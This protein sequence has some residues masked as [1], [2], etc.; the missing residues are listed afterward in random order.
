M[1]ILLFFIFLSYLSYGQDKIVNT[2][3]L[4]KTKSNRIIYAVNLHPNTYAFKFNSL[5]TRLNK[6]FNTFNIKTDFYKAYFKTV[7]TINE[8]KGVFK[9]FSPQFSSS[10]FSLSLKN[11]YKN[12]SICFYLL[13]SCK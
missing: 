10:S 5:V 9:A 3:L 4:D 13:N 7:N 2:F 6:N 11:K 12:G 1:K 8:K